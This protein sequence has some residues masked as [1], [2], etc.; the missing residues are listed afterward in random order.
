MNRLQSIPDWPLAHL[1][2]SPEFLSAARDPRFYMKVLGEDFL[3]SHTGNIA[4][5]A[6]EHRRLERANLKWDQALKHTRS[7]SNSPSITLR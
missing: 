4:N 1:G 6:A 5:L 3:N 7:P 2:F